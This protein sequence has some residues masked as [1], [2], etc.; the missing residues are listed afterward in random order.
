MGR[1]WECPFKP[2]HYPQLNYRP[3]GSKRCYL[4]NI[5]NNPLLHERNTRDRQYSQGGGIIN[6]N[7]LLLF[8][9]MYRQYSGITATDGFS[10]D[11]DYKTQ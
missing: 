10:S 1:V 5:H 2:C 3:V 8:E 7:V 11:N 9:A 6:I 4:L